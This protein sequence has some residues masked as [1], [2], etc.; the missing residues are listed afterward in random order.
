MGRVW[1]HRDHPPTHCL[2]GLD[3]VVRLAVPPLLLRRHSAWCWLLTLTHEVAAQEQTSGRTN[4]TLLLWL[5]LHSP[6]GMETSTRWRSTEGG[7]VRADNDRSDTNSL[8]H[9]PPPHSGCIRKH[10]KEDPAQFSFLQPWLFFWIPP[11]T[12]T[13]PRPQGTTAIL[14][15]YDLHFQIYGSMFEDPQIKC[16]IAALRSFPGS[17]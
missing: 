17:I 6:S 9:K 5:Q 2:H 8:P 13:A 14:R 3:V 16:N 12:E 4:S 11:W 7:R 1:N 10:F 15:L